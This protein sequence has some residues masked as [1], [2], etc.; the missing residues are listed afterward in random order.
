M[1]KEIESLKKSLTDHDGFSAGMSRVRSR[2]LDIIIRH[3]E[4]MDSELRLIKSS[5]SIYHD[6]NYLQLIIEK[7]WL[8]DDKRADE[9]MIAVT[10]C[11]KYLI[12]RTLSLPNEKGIP[13]RTKSLYDKLKD[14]SEMFDKLESV[15]NSRH[16]FE[17]DFSYPNSKGSERREFDR[18]L[19]AGGTLVF[20][21]LKSM[22]DGEQS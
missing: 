10:D 11:L 2:D 1:N 6:G 14:K 17:A 22:I 4:S 9:I 18:G 19:S 13:V 5:N 16:D 20:N 12:N 21:K 15:I 8:A 7:M 3:Y